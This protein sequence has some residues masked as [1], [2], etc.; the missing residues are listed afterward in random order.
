MLAKFACLERDDSWLE[1]FGS[2]YLVLSE[3]YDCCWVRGRGK[4]V[5][6]QMLTLFRF[7]E[8]ESHLRSNEHYLS[9]SESKAW[10]KIQAFMGTHD[11]C[12]TDAALYQLSQQANWELVIMLVPSKLVKWWINDYEYMKVVYLN[13]GLRCEYESNLHSNVY[14]S[15][16]LWSEKQLYPYINFKLTY[17]LKHPDYSTARR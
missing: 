5:V 4:C 13:C 6:A 14:L 9:S 17:I 10:M 15:L 2:C 7:C 12:D 16:E 11:L 1:F 3:W 8:Y